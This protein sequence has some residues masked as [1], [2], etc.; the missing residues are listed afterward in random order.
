M[1]VAGPDGEAHRQPELRGRCSIVRELHVY[2]SAVAV[3][4]RDQAKFQ[5]QVRA[6]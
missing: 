3:H 1:Q 2:G 6:L 4:A 5:H